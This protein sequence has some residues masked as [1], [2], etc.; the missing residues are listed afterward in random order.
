M[1]TVEEYIDARSTFDS[2][3][4]DVQTLIIM[5]ELQIGNEYCSDDM[6]N[7]A[8]ALLVMHWLTLPKDSAGNSSTVGS[9]KSEKEG[10]L[11]RSYGFAGS[12]S[13]KDPFY[14]QTSYGL[15]LLQLNR[16]CFIIPRNRFV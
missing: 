2:S 14:A 15:E 3:D 1:P 8:V 13:V 6:R 16:Q 12:I 9:I 11:A 7:Q 4:S 5:A 10:D